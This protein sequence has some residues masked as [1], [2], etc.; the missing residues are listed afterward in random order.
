MGGECKVRGDAPTIMVVV[1][2]V[3]QIAQV[4]IICD[5]Q[6]AKTIRGDSRDM[7]VKWSDTAVVPGRHWYLLKVIQK[8]KEMAWTSPI[9]VEFE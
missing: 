3:S 2:G 4:D 1:H 9:W 7:T 6:T 5:G 8:D